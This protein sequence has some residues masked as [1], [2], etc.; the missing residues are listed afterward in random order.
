MDP[1]PGPISIPLLL[2]E[3]DIFALSWATSGASTHLSF[4]FT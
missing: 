2:A 3:L 4:A 1:S